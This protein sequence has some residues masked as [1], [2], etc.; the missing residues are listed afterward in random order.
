MNKSDISTRVASEVSLSKADADSAVNAVLSAI[1]DALARGAAVNIAGFGTFS[2]KSRPERQGRNA[3]T[4]ESITIAA[5][6]VPAFKAANALRRSV[7]WR[8]FSTWSQVRS[9]DPM[10]RRCRWVVATLAG[11]LERCVTA[12]EEIHRLLFSV[13]S[14]YVV[15]LTLASILNA[16]VG[17][18]RVSILADHPVPIA[19]VHVPVRGMQPRAPTGR[20]LNYL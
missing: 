15:D 13:A 10:S 12:H 9:L 6:T 2:V 7:G 17:Q 4:G 14:G 5:S 3:R 18:R 1:G 16:T 8:C 19:I 11:Q 20:R